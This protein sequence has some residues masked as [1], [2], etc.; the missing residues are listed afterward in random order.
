VLDGIKPGERLVTKGS[1]LLKSEAQ[2]GE[3]GEEH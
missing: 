2:K 3:L 1:F